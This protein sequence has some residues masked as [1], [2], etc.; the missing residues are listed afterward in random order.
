[1]KSRICGLFSLV[2]LI[3]PFN[4]AA[5]AQTSD[6]PTL[7]AKTGLVTYTWKGDKHIAYIDSDNR[8]HELQCLSHDNYRWQDSSLP[9][10]NAP[11]N[12]VLPVGGLVVYE[13]N[14]DKHIAYVGTDGRVHELQCLSGNNYRWQ[15][16]PLPD[17]SAPKNT[18]LPQ[19]GL[20]AYMW[21]GDKHIVY[22]GRDNRAHELHC[23]KG[24]NYKC[25]DVALS[26]GSPFFDKP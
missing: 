24:N 13:W 3:V 8:V 10:G 15:D 2:T 26:K 22:I 14:G 12:S 23:A 19:P 9:D 11:K 18:V 16:T 21:E 4:A 1:M 17:P 20:V 5:S 25:Q 6:I 7:G